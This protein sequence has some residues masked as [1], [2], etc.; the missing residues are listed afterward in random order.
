MLHQSKGPTELNPM[1]PE[2]VG[3][4]MSSSVGGLSAGFRAI[5]NLKLENGDSQIVPMP[6][7]E[8]RLLSEK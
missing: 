8:E 7:N 1:W 2:V 6:M 4:F 5:W 3:G